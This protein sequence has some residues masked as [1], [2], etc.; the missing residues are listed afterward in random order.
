MKYPLVA[1][2]LAQALEDV[3]G[4]SFEKALMARRPDAK[5][6]YFDGRHSGSD[7]PEVLKAVSEAAQVVIA[8]YVG[9]GASKQVL[10]DGKAAQTFGLLGTS[11]EL[12]SEV[13]RTAS[14]KTVV[15]ALG[16]P[17]LISGFPEIQTYICTYAMAATSEVSA[18]KAIFGETQNHATLPVGLPG[19]APRGF[20]LPWPRQAGTT[21]D[22]E[23]ISPDEV[24]VGRAAMPPHMD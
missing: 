2:L 20:S 17:Y 23:L 21:M 7:V 15:V 14:G 22:L 8:A 24:G 16:S 18:V 12:L 10:I 6:F 3:N 19:V 9:H 13:L 11:G 5:V 4:R 1:I